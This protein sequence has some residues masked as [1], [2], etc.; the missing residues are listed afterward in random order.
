MSGGGGGNLRCSTLA[1]KIY[2]GTRSAFNTVLALKATCQS[3]RLG[4]DLG[5]NLIK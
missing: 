1:V 5:A 4:L 3:Y 2:G